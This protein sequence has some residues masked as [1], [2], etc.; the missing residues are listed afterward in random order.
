MLHSQRIS[1]RT[2]FF[3]RSSLFSLLISTTHPSSS[4]SA[5]FPS[6]LPLS[7]SL[8]LLINCYSLVMQEAARETTKDTMDISEKGQQ[9][10][11]FDLNAEYR[12]GTGAI[13]VPNAHYSYQE[14]VEQ[15]KAIL[16]RVMDKDNP[17]V[18]W[19]LPS[20]RMVW[21]EWSVFGSHSRNWYG[22]SHGRG[23]SRSRSIASQWSLP[24]IRIMLLNLDIRLVLPN[25]T[26]VA[27]SKLVR[28]L[29]IHDVTSAG[30]WWGTASSDCPLILSE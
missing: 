27:L 24:A 7:F 18:C 9:C 16:D 17:Y 26:W 30:V 28:I 29:D 13:T 4:S 14:A 19:E 6:L 8:S 10:S 2:C 12:S 11:R 5:V 23:T 3:Q 25:N 1:R 20:V 22:T 21:Q 15:V